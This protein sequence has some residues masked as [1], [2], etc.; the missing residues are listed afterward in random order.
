MARYIKSKIVNIPRHIANKRIYKDPPVLAH[1]LR[2][3][4]NS[5]FLDLVNHGWHG[6]EVEISF[7]Y[8]VENAL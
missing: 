8:D 4:A 5:S 1:R 3:W 7:H 2:E 6:F